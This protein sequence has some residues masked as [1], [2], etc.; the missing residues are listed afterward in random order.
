M[1]TSNLHD[2]ILAVSFKVIPNSI[3][4]TYPIVSATVSNSIG[5]HLCRVCEAEWLF[6]VQSVC[7][8]NIHLSGH[9][10][11]LETSRSHTV[12]NLENKVGGV[13]VMQLLAQYWLTRMAI[14]AEAL[15]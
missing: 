1:N 14:W 6:L 10:L 5:S 8:R 15:S 9:V 11:A 4:S 7:L 2:E 3:C 12:L 13:G